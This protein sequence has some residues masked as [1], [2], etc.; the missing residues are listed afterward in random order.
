MYNIVSIYIE[1]ISIR[2]T[3]FIIIELKIFLPLYLTYLLIVIIMH[4]CL[5]VIYWRK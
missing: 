1:P 5:H 3:T 2:D 4:T